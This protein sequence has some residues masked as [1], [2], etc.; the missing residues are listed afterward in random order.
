MDKKLGVIVPYRN[1]YEHLNIFKEKITNYLNQEDIP[2]EL[3]IVQQDNAKLFNRGMLLNIGFKYAEQL[4]CDYVVFHDVD[5]IPTNVDYSYYHKPIHLATNVLTDKNIR[6]ENFE[7]YFGG[8][9]MFPM[10]HFNLINGYSNKYWGW[11]YEDD[12]L[13]LRCVKKNIH[14]DTLNLKNIKPKNKSL[15]FN[16]IDAYVKTK[17]KLNL[18]EDL[19]ISTTFF[20]DDFTYDYLKES[21][22]FNVFTIPGYDTSISYN[23]FSRY[24]FCTFDR[25]KKPYYINTPIT[26]NYKTN[27][28]ITINSVDK[29]IKMYQDG[30]LIKTLEYEKRLLQYLNGDIF[31]GV[32]DPNRKGDEKFFKGYIDNF[33]IFPNV[34]TDDEIKNL[35]K[36]ELPEDKILYYDSNYIE[37]YELIDLSGNENNG[38]IVN[39]DIQD[40][41][42]PNIKQIKIPW[43]RKSYFYSLSHEENGFFNNKW[44]DQSTRW[45]QLRFFNEVSKNDDL[46]LNDGLSDLQFIEY[47]IENEGN[48]TTINVGI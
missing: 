29:I 21:D 48:I 18:N 41:D 45:N 46:L 5:L 13:L 1:R 11:G 20:P 35:I 33:G 37:D 17:L 12:D 28:T 47:G 43:R 4:K 32:G 42:L 19:T 34:L 3:I 39:C 7:Q 31:L 38:K 23:S 8:V 26:P 22:N 27:I 16:G 2:F 40:L 25:D 30:I 9:T 10:N 36:G 6:K 44:K 14:L 15:Y 24:N